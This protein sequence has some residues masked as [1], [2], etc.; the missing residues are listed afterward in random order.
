M[1]P[2]EGPVP[3][4]REVIPRGRRELWKVVGSQGDEDIK[5]EDFDLV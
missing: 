5:L 2:A 4:A 1:R 3:S